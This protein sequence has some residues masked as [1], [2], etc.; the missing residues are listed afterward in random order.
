[1]AT[2]PEY[3]VNRIVTLATEMKDA[4]L[5]GDADQID[6]RYEELKDYCFE[7]IDEGKE[8][9][10]IW[11]TL[12]DFT[13]EE[14]AALEYYQ[15]AL[16][17]AERDGESTH[18]VLIAIGERHAD[19]GRVELARDFLGRGLQAAFAAGDPEMVARADTLLSEL[20]RPPE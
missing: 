8:C 17:V 11:E 2:L 18:S 6:E 10:I 15:Q 9:A 1:M 14:D 13:R 12:G 3:I 7:L 16:A 4:S 19:S 5:A 20:G